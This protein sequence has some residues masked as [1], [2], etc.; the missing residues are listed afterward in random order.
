MLSIRESDL[1]DIYFE[2]VRRVKEGIKLPER[3]TV[4][5]AGYDFFAIE[6]VEIE[7]FS[8]NHK[9]IM[10][11]TGVKVKLPPS[12][13]LMLANRSSNPGK[14]DLVMPG[15]IGIIDSDYY[16][17]P[18]NEGEILFS[19]YNVGDQTRVIKKGERLGQGIIMPFIKTADDNAGG[20]RSGG[21]GSTGD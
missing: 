15:S 4:G 12:M 1:E 8:E 16:N 17:N 5:S 6:D 9:P 21:F 3:S 2:K 20:S 7:P 10:I 19:F 18:D 11:A 14:L 13:Y